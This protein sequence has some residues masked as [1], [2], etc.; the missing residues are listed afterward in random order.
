MPEHHSS[1]LGP[2]VAAGFAAAV[3]SWVFWFLVQIPHA[4]VAAPIAAVLVLGSQTTVMAWRLRAH[5]GGVGTGALAGLVA[6]AVDML[7]LGALLGSKGTGAGEVRPD[8]WM[9]VLGFTALNAVL[10]LAAGWAAETLR[11]DG[12][13]TDWL[14]ALAATAA[15]AI[16]PLL[17]IGGLVTSTESGLAVPDWPRTYRANM[18]LYPVAGMVNSRVFLEHAHRLFGTMAGFAIYTLMLATVA[19]AHRKPAR[20]TFWLLFI[21]LFGAYVSSVVFPVAGVS[22]TGTVRAVFHYVIAGLAVPG[23]ILAFFCGGRPA[24]AT[25]LLLVVFSQGIAGGLRVI[26]QSQLLAVVHGISGQLVFALAVALFAWYCGNT[27][28]H[29]DTHRPPRVFAQITLGAV[30][31]QLIFGAMFRHLGSPHPL[32]AHMGWAFVVAISALVLAALSMRTEVPRLKRAGQWLIG[33]VSV[34]F[35]L[36]WLA[37]F[38]VV[39]A[40]DR[41][42]IP[43]AE[44]L[45]QAQD[46]PLLET[47][48]ATAHQANG[49]FVLALVTLTLV[50]SWRTHRGGNA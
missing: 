13:S 22:E 21:G 39:S 45:A 2:A 31:L 17:F 20:I 42:P 24:A 3:A 10:G 49:A 38:A 8:A 50:W 16:A 25:A 23:L 14:T 41:G 12:P 47:L 46:V 6:A 19:R 33:A 7:W 30:L 48:V 4:H 1:A 32:W 11:R 5:G 26:G 34:Q 18:F 9:I 43:T 44:R 36:G 29:T 35:V 27:K 37:F 40:D 28:Q 15:V